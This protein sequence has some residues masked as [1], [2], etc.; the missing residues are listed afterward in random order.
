MSHES[1]RLFRRARELGGIVEHAVR[2]E[3]PGFTG[4]Y[5]SQQLTD[6]SQI[7]EVRQFATERFVDLGKIDKGEVGEDGM[8]VDDRLLPLSTFFGC[9]KDGQLQATAR[10]LWHE[11]C[12]IDELRLP[13]DQISPDS[14]L[15]LETSYLPGK[16]A[17]IG[18]MAKKK[19]APSIANLELLHSMWE[20]A[21]KNQIEAFVCGLDPKIYPWF[22][23]MFGNALQQLSDGP[24]DEPGTVE[25]PGIT[26]PQVPLLIDVN[27]AIAD[28]RSTEG[29]F[30]A[31]PIMKLIGHIIT[32]GLELGTT[33]DNSLQNTSAKS[34]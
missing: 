1:R 22:R 4:R 6:D 23:A 17:E 33:T 7:A 16:V 29:I 25:F 15:D 19:A 28:Q 2:V 8:L 34:Y 13:L 26:G 12:S 5:T 14:R 9:Y 27:R 18:S 32:R 30:V 31:K 3:V 24:A 10:L 11:G 20:F 21:S